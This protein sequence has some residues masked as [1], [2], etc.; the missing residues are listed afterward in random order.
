M[1]GLGEVIVVVVAELGVGGIA[2]RALEV[3]V[4]L[5]RRWRASGPLVVAG[6]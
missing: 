4:V 5:R 1:A 6:F 3:V 2:A